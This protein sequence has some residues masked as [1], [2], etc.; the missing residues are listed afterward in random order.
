M[1]HILRGENQRSNY[2]KGKL[3]DGRIRK[4]NSIGMIWDVLEYKFNVALDALIAFKAR[5]GHVQVPQ[6]HK[7][8]CYPL[9][10]WVSGRKSRWDKM[11]EEHQKRL[12]EIGL[13]PSSN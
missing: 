8:D 9:G 10:T 12:L 7:E 4:L 1:C 6:K 5:E 11:S 2:K 13:R 3:D